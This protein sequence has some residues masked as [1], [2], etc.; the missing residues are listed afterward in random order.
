MAA[1]TSTRVVVLALIY[2]DRLASRYAVSDSP[3]NY[4]A[5]QFLHSHS[6]AT[7]INS[8][9]LHLLMLAGIMTATK[10]TEDRQ[11]SHRVWAYFGGVS[12]R[13]LATLERTFC[14][15]SDF[16][17]HV[18]PEEYYEW[19]QRIRVQL[20]HD[21]IPATLPYRGIIAR[22]VGNERLTNREVLNNVK[23]GV[24]QFGGPDGGALL[25]AHRRSSTGTWGLSQSK[26]IGGLEAESD[27]EECKESDEEGDEEM[28]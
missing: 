24:S 13:K 8:S 2:I 3:A 14:A 27:E 15:L 1:D 7:L 12:K 11:R 26:G 6:F 16:N 18:Q 19:Y 21:H 4:P 22:N 23:A 28:E 5:P 9:T 17:F 20:T 25:E 10:L